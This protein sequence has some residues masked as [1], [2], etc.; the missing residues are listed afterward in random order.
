MTTTPIVA[1]QIAAFILAI[2]HLHSQSNSTPSPT[3]AASAGSIK[4]IFDTDFLVPPQDDGLAL[5]LALKSPELKILGITTVAGNGEIHKETADALRELEIAGRTDIPVYMGAVRPLIHAK[6]DW[7]ATVHGKWWSDEPPAPPPGGFAKIQAQKGNAIDFIVRTVNENPGQI[8]IVAIGPLTN[9][10]M[11]IRQDPTFAKNVKQINIMGGSIGMLDG[12]AG[13]VTPNA[14]FNF[15]VDPEAAQVVLQSGIPVNLTPLNVT[16][17]TD[18]SDDYVKQTIAVENPLT[19]LIKDRMNQMSGRGPA[20]T[21]A[22]NPGVAR[23]G[24]Q[25]FDELTVATVIDP[26]LV[27]SR[28]LYVDVD[29]NHGPDYG[30]SVGGTKPWEGG[31]DA[32]PISVQYDVDNER[33]MEMFVKRLTGK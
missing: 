5:A 31:E 13:N 25:M 10:A 3:G 24:R 1:T 29:I 21:P 11:A 26:T 23:G 27:K 20:R 15:W 7:A 12:G 33:F 14:E 6:T 19:S 8:T 17:K 28:S 16:R 9:I 22:S 30:V 4:V 2:G 32:K 18:F